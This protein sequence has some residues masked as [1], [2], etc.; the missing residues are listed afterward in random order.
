MTRSSR[1]CTVCPPAP[2]HHKPS[3]R[4]VSGT[5][6]CATAAPHFEAGRAHL[7]R[8]HVGV[9]QGAQVPVVVRADVARGVAQDDVRDLK[10]LDGQRHRAV[11][12]ER[13]QQARQ[14]RCARHLAKRPSRSDSFKASVT[15][16]NALACRVGQRRRRTWNSAVLGLAMV[17]ADPSSSC[18]SIAKFSSVE[19]YAAANRRARRRA[20]EHGGIQG[21]AVKRG[22][23][24]YQRKGQGLRVAREGDLAAE[25]V[26]ELVDGQ[27][28]RNRVGLRETLGHAVEAVRDRHVL[29]H[30]ARVENVCVGR[31]ASSGR[32]PPAP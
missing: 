27:L 22:G 25:Q 6:A 24:Q 2:H 12:A 28:L 23:G 16:S 11:A 15:L 30:I 18:L 5:V 1:P 20:R 21:A 8:G 32:P 19:H 7:E 17:T 26:R 31:T 9:V 13:L 3:H 10:N 4:S 29:H 14:Q